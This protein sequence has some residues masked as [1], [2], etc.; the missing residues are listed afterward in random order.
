MIEVISLSFAF[1]FG[2]L[3]RLVGLPPLVGFLAAGFALNYFGPWMG[4]PHQTGEVLDHVA[5]LG[6]LL[7]LFTVGLKLK[8]R[9]LLERAVA[10]GALLHFLLTVAVFLGVFIALPTLPGGETAL[11]LAIALSFSSTVLAAKVLEA[12]RELRAFHGRIAIGILI[13]QDLL[14]LL[15]LALAGGQEPSPWGLLLFTLP[16][17]RPVLHWLLDLAG[18]DELVVVMGVVLA[19]VVGGWGFDLFGLSPEVGALAMGVMLSGHVRAQEIS[20]A[21]WGL[22]ELFLVGFFLQIGMSGLPDLQ[23]VLFGLGLA[24]LLPVKGALFF[25]LLLWFGLRARNAFLAALSLSSYSEFG[26]IVATAVLP[27]W[28]IPL[29]LAVTFSFVLSA[30]LNRFSHALF[31]RFESRLR[32]FERHSRHPDEQPVS[33]GDAELLIVGMGRTGTAAFNVLTEHGARVAGVDADPAKVS[34]HQRQGRQVVYADAEDICFWNGVELEG[35][36]AVVLATPD[37]EGKLIAARRL[38]RREFSGLIVA[39]I[40]YEDEEAS[41][42]RA[43]VDEVYMAMVGAGMGLASTAWD[44]L[45]QDRRMGR[46]R[47]M[48]QRTAPPP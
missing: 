17:L 37:F 9:N 44:R 30:P 3:V 11:L 33:L 19:I 39:Q 15:V 8:L 36:R 5:H 38:R 42:R 13:I 28:L 23:A 1:F 4:L 10:G 41:L 18:H 16:L 6:V 34:E 27:E 14:A 12:K 29:A 24:L 31:D 48:R 2:M 40:M 43:G 45:N 20:N 26:L 22:K 35:I 32:R 21:L 7:L 47:G 25:F 46:Q